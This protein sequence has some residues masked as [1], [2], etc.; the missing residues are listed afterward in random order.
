MV[1]NNST[2]NEVHQKPSASA[3]QHTAESEQIATS[4]KLQRS[5]ALEG[6]RDAVWVAEVGYCSISNNIT[7]IM[8]ALEALAHTDGMA[9]GELLKR[10]NA[11]QKLARVGVR[12]AFDMENTIDCEREAMQD[13]LNALVG[14][15]A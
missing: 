4:A 10:L 2:A 11:I 14:G 13:K 6:A 7:P 12:V 9:G 1:T 15:A 8:V 5:T 3:K